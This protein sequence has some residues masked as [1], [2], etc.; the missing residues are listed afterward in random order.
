[1]ENSQDL[2]VQFSNIN[3][4]VFENAAVVLALVSDEGKIININKTAM[5]MLGKQKAEILNRLGGEVFNCTNAW[6]RGKVVCGIGKHCPQC[7]VRNSVMTTFET[8]KTIYKRQG[9][10]D[11]VVNGEIIRLQLLITTAVV[12]IEGRN[13]VLLTIDDITELKAQQ[14]KLKDAIA[15]KDKFFSIIS[16]D[17]RGPIG[18]ILGLSEILKED[19]KEKNYESLEEYVHVISDEIKKTHKLLE[20]LLLWSHSQKGKLSLKPEVLNAQTLATDVIGLLRGLADKKEVQI[21]NEIPKGLHV[22]ADKEMLSTIIR[23]LVSNAIKFTDKD[24]MITLKAEK[25]KQFVHFSIS[26]TGIGMTEKMKNNLFDISV[27]ISRNGTNNEKGT[28]LGLMLCKEFV[29][30]HGGKIWVE[31]KENQ[32][33]TMFFVIPDKV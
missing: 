1:M 8:G 19:L 3:N 16:H 31:S 32:G 14:N 13:Y 29:E 28:G 12:D 24:G 10:L 15:T 2:S 33:T 6:S 22:K 4:K 18:G 23:N 7:S 5:D 25:K 20:N 26:D 27:N 9:H 11:I 21:I 17:L 30:K